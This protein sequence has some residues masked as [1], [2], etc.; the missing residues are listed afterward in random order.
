MR[1]SS[2]VRDGLYGQDMRGS[3]EVMGYR[4][5]PVTHNFA[6]SS[7]G[8]VAKQ[9]YIIINNELNKFVV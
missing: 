7:Q 5:P 2:S 8:L 6:L 1:P 3:G 9:V 4:D